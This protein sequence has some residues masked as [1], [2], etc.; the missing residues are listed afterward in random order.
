M[1]KK[2]VYS[3]VS[4]GLFG[5]SSLVFGQGITNPLG[6]TGDFSSLLMKM[7]GTVGDL[8]AGVGTIM[9]IVAG[10]FY[11]TSAGSTERMGVAKKTLTWAIIGM[12]VGLSAAAI[13]SWIQ[14]AT[15]SPG[16]GD[17]QDFIYQASLVALDLPKISLKF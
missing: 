5:A 17:G 9:L 13:V 2:I 6:S 7:A 11:V 4:L 8:V 3:I 1:N 16:E 15:D 10:I 14:S 12:V